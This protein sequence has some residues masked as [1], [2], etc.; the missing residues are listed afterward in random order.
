M[1]SFIIN[2]SIHNIERKRIWS[3]S[4][5]KM[6]APRIISHVNYNFPILIVH[7]STFSQLIPFQIDLYTTIA[8]SRIF[9][10]VRWTSS[11]EWT[12]WFKC[13]FKY[14]NCGIQITACQPNFR[15]LACPFFDYFC[16]MTW[17]LYKIDKRFQFSILIQNCCR[18]WKFTVNMTFQIWPIQNEE[19]ETHVNPS[20]VAWE[21]DIRKKGLFSN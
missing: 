8:C 21:S 2:I 4:I 1:N 16:K 5:S 9:V 7:Y 17:K 14:S 10:W 6:S 19:I 18:Y 11:D 20:L 3:V 12:V 13:G 15:V